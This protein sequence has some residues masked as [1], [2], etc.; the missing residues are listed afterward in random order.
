MESL[1]EL[2]DGLAVQRRARER[3]REK[4]RESNPAGC[5]I[6]IQLPVSCD[7]ETCRRLL[8]SAVASQLFLRTVTSKGYMMGDWQRGEKRTERGE[9]EDEEGKGRGGREGPSSLSLSPSHSLTFS[10]CGSPPPPGG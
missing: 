2:F 7:V 8:S 3:E 5:R 6:G 1:W 10:I 9:S 4:A